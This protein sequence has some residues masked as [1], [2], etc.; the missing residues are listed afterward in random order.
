M[1]KEK[2]YIAYQGNKYTIEWY[3]DEKDYSQT[4]AYFEKLS[5]KRQDKVFYLFSRMADFGII[6]DLT[7]F[8]NEADGIYAF[9][10]QPD[11][12]LCFFFRGNKII[13]TNAFEKQQ[14]KLPVQE[15]RKALACKTQ[16]EIRLTEGTYYDT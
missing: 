2:E 13:V 4:L 6:S 16:Y 7:K 11:R 15:K 14:E 3:Y 12:F 9:K 10:P 5:P 8:R 1:K